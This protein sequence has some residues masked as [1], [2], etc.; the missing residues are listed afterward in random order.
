MLTADQDDYAALTAID[1]LGRACLLLPFTRSSL[2]DLL[3]ELMGRNSSPAARPRESCAAIRG[4]RVLLVEDNPANQRIARELLEQ[5]GL[6]VDVAANG[7]E[8]VELVLGSPGECPWQLILM[9]LQMPEMDGFAATACIRKEAR[10]R[11]LPIVAMTGHVLEED[12][13]RCLEA[14]ME[15]G[16]TTLATTLAVLPVEV[17]FRKARQPALLPCTSLFIAAPDVGS[18]NLS[19]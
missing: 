4:A 15:V 19:L 14:G 18:L 13:K 8:A 10:F 2:L 9:D 12:R 6:Q 3:A 5:A 1:R 16:K 7:R 17:Q 11:N